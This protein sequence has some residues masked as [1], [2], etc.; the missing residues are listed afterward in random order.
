MYMFQFAF[1]L[2]ATMNNFTPATH[3][4]RICLN[5]EINYMIAQPNLTIEKKI[6]YPSL[7]KSLSVTFESE[8]N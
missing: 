5:Q 2:M 6:L 4:D 8:A 1:Q 7:H 3:F